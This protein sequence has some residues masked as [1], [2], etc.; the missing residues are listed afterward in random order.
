MNDLVA[1]FIADLDKA[2]DEQV[3]SAMLRPN[4][5]KFRHGLEV[6]RYQGLLDAQNMLKELM[7]QDEDKDS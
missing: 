7:K 1:K 4:G 6:G 3:E 2:M 5:K